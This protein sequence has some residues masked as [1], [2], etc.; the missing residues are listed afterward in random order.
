MVEKKLWREEKLNRHD[1]GREK[2]IEK[3]WEWRESKGGRIYHQLRKLGSSYDW[4]RVAF[5]MDP[6]LCRAVT[7][8]FNQLHE[9][10]LIYRNSRLV[11]WSCT[12]KSAI[13]DIEVDKME[14]AGRTFLSIPGYQ[15]KVEFG[16]LVSF[17]YLVED[18]NEE[19]VVATT[20][21]ETMLGD[22]AVAVHPNDERYKH[23]HGKFVT[24]PFVDRR[25][26][27]V[28]DDFVDMN[29]G[30]GAVKITPAHDPNDYDVGKRHNLPFLTIFSDDG[31]IIGD[32]GKFAGMKRFDA[33]KEV[34]ASLKER[35]LYKETVNNPMVV[36]VCSRSKDVVEPLIK[37]QWYVKCDDMAAKAT[38]AVRSG[39]LKLIPENHVKT[40][41][42]WMDGIRDWCISRQLWWGHRIPAYFVRFSKPSEK[43]RDAQEED[44]WIVARDAA[45]AEVK[46]KLK[47]P[48]ASITLHQD[49]DVLDTWFSSGLFPFSVFGWPDNTQDVNLFYPTSLLETGHDILFFWVARMVFFGQTLLGKLPFKEVFLHPMV[50]DAHGRK[51][52][53]SLGNVI[54]PMDVI[55]GISLEG[56]HQ[57]LLDSNLDPREIDKA[58]AG[59][60]QDYPDGIPQCGTDAM[61]FAL[62]SYMTQARDIN[63]DISRVQGY[64]FFCNKLWNATKF[65]LLYFESGEKYRTVE[66]L[67]GAESK[68]DL[69]IL[70]RLSN[71]IDVFNKSFAAY[72]FAQ[73][74]QVAYSFWL[75][76]LCDIYLE[77][78]KP[79]FASDDIARKATA[80]NILYTC[81][82]LGLRLLS[83]FMPFITEELFQRLP[84]SNTDIASICVAP[85]PGKTD[86]DRKF[87]RNLTISLPFRPRRLQ[88][89]QRIHREGFRVRPE[90]CKSIQKRSQ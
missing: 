44:F 80:R 25:L 1:L 21:I 62:C 50:R 58:K 5:T 39:E 36:P 26:P 76:D 66:T 17:A 55:N 72:E 32:Y 53:K 10:G 85:F 90:G 43:P 70:S 13:S 42:F 2:F 38:E 84:R 18:T 79:I 14:V 9:K 31:F 52:S 57:Q 3:I 61:R 54:D 16:V 45:E 63:L 37:P 73:S 20:R 77:C 23:L 75:Y 86:I 8:A 22:T 65:A 74:T 88:L 49:E 40:W 24:H 71:T 19:I 29:F 64:R 46:A 82:D 35:G 59:Q 68:V 6:K 67:T 87:Q 56:L 4:D 11:N 48:G 78:L 28:C 7:E 15:D 60:K 69:W 51:M 41:N 89:H 47:F 81:L 30:T 83:P 12:L 27:I 34:L 33:R